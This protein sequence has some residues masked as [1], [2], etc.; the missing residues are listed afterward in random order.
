M[1]IAIDPNETFPHVVG[2]TTFLLRPLSLRQMNATYDFDEV[3]PDGTK[4]E[5]HGAM[6]LAVLRAGIAGWQGFK[7]AK[8]NEIP[9]ETVR[10]RVLGTMVDAVKEELLDRV[11]YAVANQLV[12]EIIRRGN[13][14]PDQG[15]G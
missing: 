8:G 14:T 10:T 12:L 15:K 9:F 13:L 2:E 4:R 5:R 6:N 11:P 3:A 7:D 1:T